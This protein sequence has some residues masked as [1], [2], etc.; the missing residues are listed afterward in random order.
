[1]SWVK[2]K[3][4]WISQNPIALVTKTKADHWKI[5]GDSQPVN[6]FDIDD[7]VKF[8]VKLLTTFATSHKTGA[9]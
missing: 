7:S 4:M 2:G 9:I 6:I 5:E 8:S 3:W 1:M